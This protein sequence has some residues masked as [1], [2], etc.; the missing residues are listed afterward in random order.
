MAT[1]LEGRFVYSSLAKHASVVVGHLLLIQ[2]FGN[3]WPGTGARQRFADS[4]A[5][6]V[7]A[8]SSANH[9]ADTH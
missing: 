1:G 5:F 3:C 9:G 4:S 2:R 7:R 8:G 6:D